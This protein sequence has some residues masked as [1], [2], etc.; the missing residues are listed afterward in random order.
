MVSMDNS[1]LVDIGV[2]K[3]ARLSTHFCY[4]VEIRWISLCKD[5]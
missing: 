3:A 1:V 5:N 4:V 2:V